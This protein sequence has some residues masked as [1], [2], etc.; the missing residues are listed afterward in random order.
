MKRKNLTVISALIAATLSFCACGGDRTGWNDPQ[1]WY[2]PANEFDTASTDV[3]YL[4]STEVLSA[5]DGNGNVCWQAQ[6]TEE[7][8]DALRGEI[9][10]VENNMFDGFNVIAPY[11]HQLTFDALTKAKERDLKKARRKVV[12]EVC[13]AFDYYMKNQNGGRPFIIAGFSQGS[14][15]AVELLKHMSDAQYSKMIA[16]YSLGYRLSAEDLRNPHIKAAA[17]E[18]DTGV[19]ISFNS[20]QTREA[21][22]PLV[23]ADAAICI[24]PLNWKTDSTPATF[25]FNETTNTVH[26][27]P[28]TNVLLVETDDPAYYYSYYELAHFYQEAG[29]DRNNLHHWDLLFYPRQIHDN[30]L[31]RTG[32]ASQSL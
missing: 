9:A 27:D 2:Q 30:A 26:I 32:N 29:V 14:M 17:G 15:M 24:N 21:I 8:L 6:L 1:R 16:C 20:T 3:L 31:L 19:V 12:E 13:S 10:W 22:W 4:V 28:E 25:Q 11:Y 7:N 18:G 5:V 23:S